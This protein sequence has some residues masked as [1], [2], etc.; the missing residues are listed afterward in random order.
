[1]TASTH[2]TCPDAATL[3]LSVSVGKLISPFVSCRPI[4][5]TCE[6]VEYETLRPKY[7]V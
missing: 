5:A 6:H 7:Q 3:F 1:M 4:Y 2:P